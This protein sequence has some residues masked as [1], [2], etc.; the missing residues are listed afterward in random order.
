ML[1]QVGN[2]RLFIEVLG[3]EW[4]VDGDEM[5]RRAVLVGL[6]GGPGLDGTR[7]RHDLAPLADVA[8]VVVP[9]QRGH[10]RSGRGTPDTWNLSTWADDVKSLCDALG[11]EHPVVLGIS[12]GGFVAQQYAAAYPGHPAGLILISTGPR[13]SSPEETVARFREVAGDEAADVVRRNLEAP[14]EENDA[15]WERVISPLMS[16]STDLL[17]RKLDAM[18]I[19]TMEVNHHFM[20]SASTMDLRTG[21]RAVRCPTLVLVGEHDPLTPLDL[22]R[23]IV[24]AIPHGLARLQ[25]IPEASHAVFADNPDDVHRTIRDFMSDRLGMGS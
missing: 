13:F 4:V 6:H 9:D 25:V 5:R 17:H 14:S 16:T 20:R 18:R 12:F 23:E 10:G 24:E 2:V 1:V 15:E 7:L 21:L 8:Q 22:G 3:Q 19:R 11:I